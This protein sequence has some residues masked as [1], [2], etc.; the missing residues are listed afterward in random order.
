MDFVPV[1]ESAKRQGLKTTMHLLEVS[2]Y[3]L[4][5]K[6]LSCITFL[7]CRM[8]I[9]LFFPRFLANT[10]KQRNYFNGS[11]PIVLVMPFTCI[12]PHWIFAI[13]F[14]TLLFSTAFPLVGCFVSLSCTKQIDVNNSSTLYVVKC[15][16]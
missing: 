15:L 5:F 14:M 10:K 2:L 9:F 12:R 8:I 7:R 16:R 6:S 11:S 4:S 13:K 1:F 3:T